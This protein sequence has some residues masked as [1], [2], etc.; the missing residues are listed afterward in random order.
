MTGLI[1]DI[2]GVGNL[3]AGELKPDLENVPLARL[4]GNSLNE[5]ATQA[6][7]ENKQLAVEC[8]PDLTAELDPAWMGRVLANLVGNAFKYTEKGGAIRVSAR[9]DAHRGRVH[10]SVRDDGEGI[11]HERKKNVFGKLVQ[12]PRADGRPSRKGTGLGLA[13]CRLVVVAHGGEI[14]VEHGPGGGTDFGF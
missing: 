1:D 9:A 4:F 2:M 14:G 3:E 13:F 10:V 7:A 5:F 11:P 8:P 6:A 12:A